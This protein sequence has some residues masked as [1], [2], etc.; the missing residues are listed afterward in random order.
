[1]GDGGADT[2][3]QKQPGAENE[4]GGAVCRRRSSVLPLNLLDTAAISQD[5][6]ALEFIAAI[7]GRQCHIQEASGRELCNSR[8]LKTVLLKNI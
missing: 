4:G 8:T 3:Q 5:G 2:G 1:M 7:A 6:S